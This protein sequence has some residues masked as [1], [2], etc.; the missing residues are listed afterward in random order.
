[1]KKPLGAI[2]AAVKRGSLAEQAGLEKNDQL[3]S[4]NGEKLRDY[5]DYRYLI[6]DESLDLKL[7]KGKGAEARVQINKEIDED[8][9]LRFTEDVFDAVKTCRC[10]CQFCFVAQLPAGLRPSLY[11]RDDDYRLSFLHGNFIT[12]SNFTEADFRR[13]LRQRLSPL[14]IS[15]HA[16]D[17][18]LRNDLMGG[19]L[20]DILS[21]L[22]RLTAG[23]IEIHAQVVVCPGVNDGPQLEKSVRDL[24][25]LHPN[26][27]SIGLVPVGITHM[28]QQKSSLQPM[29]AAPARRIIDQVEAWQKEF[30][31]RF[32]S[33]LVWAAD[34]MYLLARRNIP[35]AEEYED[36]YQRANG[37]G[38]A[39]LFL[40][41]IESEAFRRTLSKIAAQAPASTLRVIFGTGA[42]A[43]GLVARL[44]ERCNKLGIEA[45]VVVAINRLLGPTV[46]SAGLIAGA[47]W[48]TAFE[49]VPQ[50]DLAL[51]P[52]QALNHAG[53]FLDNISSREFAKR[54]GMR[55]GFAYGPNEAAA[56]LKNSNRKEQRAQS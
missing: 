3:L 50:A 23:G 18:G 34:E 55:V 49:G 51:L 22:Q 4:I 17:A 47:D 14:W 9:G 30:L 6:A 40:D 46:T 56:I 11:L 24:A 54:L 13:I 27:A 25:A 31:A 41:E 15:I 12:L 16:T 39:R 5:I 42:G 44:A 38:E 7:L 37:I 43:S 1:M 2:I 8:L 21:Q 28:M 48:L 20:P 35:R 45:R 26:L 19:G 32:G 53:R 10:N 52:R 36:F 29:S 33:R